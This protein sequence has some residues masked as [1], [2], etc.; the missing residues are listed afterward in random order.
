MTV[1]GTGPSAPTPGDAESDGPLTPDQRYLG[2]GLSWLRARLERL[3]GV[4]H[5]ADQPTETTTGDRGE[6]PVDPGL[7]AAIRASMPPA[8]SDP[9]GPP[10]PGA[11]GAD[12]ESNRTNI[13]AATDDHVDRA[14][15]AMAEA[16]AVDPPPALVILAERL[17]LSL[18]EQQVLLLCIAMELDPRIA[19]LCGAAQ[20]DRA[21]IHPTF[22]LAFDLFDN[23]AWDVVTPGRPLR[24]WRLIEITQPNG[25][26]LT[27]SV[28]RAD[29]RIVSYAMGIN[30]LDDRLEPLFTPLGATFDLTVLSPSQHA[31]VDRAAPPAAAERRAHAA[32]RARRSGWADQAIPCYGGRMGD[33]SPGPHASSPSCFRPAATTWRR[34]PACGTARAFSCP[35]RSFSMPAISI[36]LRPKV[37][38]AR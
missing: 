27:R 15:A 4:P 24:Y 17:G 28:L 34:W 37:R 23:P 32:R 20:G 16:A 11:L 25:L 2:A 22:A 21:A 36:P 1:P 12:D 19:E 7:A 3:A 29:E 9:S 38:R 6:P 5:D 13:G 33:G 26:P 31:V 18:F 8:V 30:Y 14:A 10:G 35:S